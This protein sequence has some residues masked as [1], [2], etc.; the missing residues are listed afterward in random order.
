MARYTNVFDVYASLTAEFKLPPAI[1][2]RAGAIKKTLGGRGKIT[3]NVKT[4]G[5]VSIVCALEEATS[6]EEHVAAVDGGTC[7]GGVAHWPHAA[8]LA[9]HL[10]G[11]DCFIPKQWLSFGVVYSKC[12]GKHPKR[13]RDCIIFASQMSSLVPHEKHEII[14]FTAAKLIVALLPSS[15]PQEDLI[16]AA[17]LVSAKG[18]C[19]NSIS[20]LDIEGSFDKMAKSMREGPS[21]AK[22]LKKYQAHRLPPSV[23]K[24]KLAEEKTMEED[25]KK[26]TETKRRYAVWT[27]AIDIT[28]RMNFDQKFAE[29]FRTELEKCMGKLLPITESQTDED[30]QELTATVTGGGDDDDDEDDD[31]SSF[32]QFDDE[33][34]DCLLN[35]DAVREKE[36]I[37]D[38]MHPKYKLD[39][40]H[41]QRNSK[42]RTWFPPDSEDGDQEE[43][44]TGE[45]CGTAPTAVKRST[46]PHDMIGAKK[47]RHTESQLDEPPIVKK[48][49]PTEDLFA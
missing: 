23:Y 19:C 48:V 16:T 29:Y 24:R 6:D 26:E 42:R 8:T 44:I 37:F 45:A 27:V 14:G 39:Q 46:E 7:L 1:I 28:E 11:S 25:R 22:K 12:Q 33:I 13:S 17:L 32:D 40:E 15:V 3:A 20:I 30:H 21:E 43:D 31:G 18:H 49:D 35:S 9:K 34:D 36:A 41:Q 5:V 4:I 38:A 2:T 10:G 47:M